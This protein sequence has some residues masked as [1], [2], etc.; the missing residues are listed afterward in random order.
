MAA[1]PPTPPGMS[2]V[3][4]SS[5][6]F[7]E[8]LRPPTLQAK[9]GWKT[10]E[11]ELQ[12]MAQHVHDKLQRDLSNLHAQLLNEVQA[13]V[14]QELMVVSRSFNGLQAVQSQA[15]ASKEINQDI[16]VPACT[17]LNPRLSYRVFISQHRR[18]VYIYIHM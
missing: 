2:D 13:A 17:P 12:H 16:E 15:H 3:W 14:K 10:L 18:I 8:P 9:A 4:H 7:L 6:F 11:A 5:P 1:G